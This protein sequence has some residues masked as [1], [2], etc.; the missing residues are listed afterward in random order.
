MLLQFLCLLPTF[1]NNQ[2]DLFFNTKIHANTLVFNRYQ[3]MTQI[4]SL[5]LN[6]SWF[7]FHLYLTLPFACV[8]LVTVKFCPNNIKKKNIIDGETFTKV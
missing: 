8:Y 3:K 4:D 5:T 2:K 1:S 6:S 7:F